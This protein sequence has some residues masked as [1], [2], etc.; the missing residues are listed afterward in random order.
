MLSAMSGGSNAPVPNSIVSPGVD[1]DDKD[2]EKKELSEVN[3]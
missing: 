3:A 2:K 1:K